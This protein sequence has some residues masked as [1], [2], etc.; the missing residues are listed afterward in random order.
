M[1]VLQ[2]G[3]IGCFGQR[4]SIYKQGH[5]EME[6]NKFK[7]EHPLGMHHPLPLKGLKIYI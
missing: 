6:N 5:L 3:E 4:K 7:K 1:L 2:K